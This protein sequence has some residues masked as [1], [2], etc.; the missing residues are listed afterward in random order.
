MTIKAV[1]WGE[2]VHEQKNAVVRDLPAK[3]CT[4]TIAAALNRIRASR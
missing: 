3:A 2:N 4:R 1:V